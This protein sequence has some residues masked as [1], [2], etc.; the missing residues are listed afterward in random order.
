ILI[1]Y[2][3]AVCLLAVSAFAQTATLRGQ[4]TDES[5]AIIQ[6]AK[7]SVFGP[8]RLSRTGASANDGSYS[9]ADL[10][11]GSFTV[12]AS[13][14]GLA[15]RQAAKIDLK[16]GNQTLNLLLNVVAEKQEVTVEDSGSAAVSTDAASNA[17]AVV[18][19]G[20]DLDALSD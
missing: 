11:V 17:S 19:R 9:F 5:G 18:I 2:L 8:G 10:P 4:V 13:A 20:S 12:R 16:S 7:I 15:L 14:P 3:V 1:R 6:G